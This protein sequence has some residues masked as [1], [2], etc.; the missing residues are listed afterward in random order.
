M[1]INTT[2]KAGNIENLSRQVDL[3]LQEN[4]MLHRTRN[5]LLSFVGVLT[6]GLVLWSGQVSA[7]V[8]WS[9]VPAGCSM[10]NQENRRLVENTIGFQ[11]DSV[12]FHN[13]TEGIIRLYCPI[14]NAQLHGRA[15]RL[16]RFLYADASGTQ[17]RTGSVSAYLRAVDRFTGAFESFGGGTSEPRQPSQSGNTVD[18][19]SQANCSYNPITDEVGQCLAE[20]RPDL[21]GHIFDFQQYYYYVEAFLARTDS[22]IGVELFGVDILD[23]PLVIVE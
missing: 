2:V 18:H 13:D 19:R 22:A 7:A 16:L 1:K 20:I 23:E 17:N 15:G 4:P 21:G 8:L 14:T 6:L 3:Q 9:S 5:H 10:V 11:T 12:T